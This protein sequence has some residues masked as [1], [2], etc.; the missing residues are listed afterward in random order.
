M[1]VFEGLVT[2]DS[3]TGHPKHRIFIADLLDTTEEAVESSARK[4]LASG[5][6]TTDLE[7]SLI[8]LIVDERYNRHN[9]GSFLNHSK[10]IAEEIL[11]SFYLGLTP[12]SQGRMIED[13]WTWD[14]H[15]LEYTHDYIQWLF[16]LK[17]RSNFNLTAPVLNDRVIV[18]FMDN[19]LLKKRLFR[20]LSMMLKFYG[21]ESSK[22]AD[23]ILIKKTSEYRE[24]SMLWVTE[25]NHNYLRITRIMTCLMTLG[26]QSYARAFFDCLAN[27]YIEEGDEIGDVTYRYWE[28][29]VR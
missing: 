9:V 21:L 1:N 18:F 22:G 19:D 27:I 14:Y 23:N 26:L 16:P 20:S 10:V 17:E 15:R 25:G 28:C 29:A 2:S 5:Q 3:S 24:R 6:P 11:A 13:I 4:L 8:Q 12:D 7:R